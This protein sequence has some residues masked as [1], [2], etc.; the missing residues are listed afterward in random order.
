MTDIATY[1]AQKAL[2][3]LIKRTADLDQSERASLEKALQAVSA[4]PKPVIAGTIEITVSTSFREGGSNHACIRV[5]EEGLELSSGGSS[6]D[7]TVGSDSFSRTDFAHSLAS[8]EI[9]GD[10]MLDGWEAIW[11][12]NLPG[13]G[14]PGENEPTVTVE[15]DSEP[16]NEEED[17]ED[18][19]DTFAT[20]TDQ[21]AGLLTELRN[22]APAT[23]TELAGRIPRHTPGIYAF[24]H[25]GKPVY[26]GRTRDLRRRLGE[27][28]RESS[29]HYSASFAFLR[30]RQAAKQAGHDL[31]GFTRRELAHEHAAFPALF[32][33]EKAA[34]AGMQVRWV[35][36]VD[37]VVQALLEV[38][39]A[40]TLGTPFNSF[41][42]S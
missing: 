9:E 33:A 28:G 12:G 6:Y 13:N 39:A 18:A 35:T 11:Y 21:L 23:R 15:D 22:C 2:S 40:L 4:Y 37:P 8:D 26:V 24:Y 27:H 3:S 20:Y 34:V 19:A 1:H 10:E 17:T 14:E 42:T 16:W 36:V 38:Y 25:D 41:E 31:V 7:P 30:A 32:A 5:G 29:S